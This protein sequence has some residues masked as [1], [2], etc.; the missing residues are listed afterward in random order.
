MLVNYLRLS[1]PAYLTVMAGGLA[2]DFNYPLFIGIIAAATHVLMGPDHLA[3]VTPLVFDVQKKHWKIGFLWGVGHL[4]GMLLIGVLFYFFKEFIPI[5]TISTYSEQFVGVILIGLGFWA[6]YRIKNKQKN[7]AHPHFHNKKD[8][9]VFVH[10]HEHTHNE[11]EHSHTHSKQVKQNNFTAV[12]V[13][14]IHGFAG[15]A[16]F[17]LL[18][19]VLGFQTK[20]ESL[21]YIIGFAIGTVVTMLIY[22]LL[23]GKFQNKQTEDKPKPLYT[24][25]QFWSG[26]LA[27]GVGVYWILCN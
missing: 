22:T 10:I 5:E 20:L 26:V 24:N 23:L 11:Q 9:E 12:S 6:F 2:V 17:V 15:I 16:H 27:I 3:A 14:V 13:G 1:V 7:H 21:Q 8:T 4:I 25:L 18:L 19:P